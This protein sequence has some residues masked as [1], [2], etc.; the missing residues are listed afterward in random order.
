MEKFYEPTS[1]GAF[2][3]GHFN[4]LFKRA[5]LVLISQSRSYKGI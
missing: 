1:F 5:F 2:L 3:E 4:G